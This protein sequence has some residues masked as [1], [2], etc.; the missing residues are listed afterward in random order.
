[1]TV[2][3][4]PL[5]E[6]TFLG[7]GHNTQGVT[8]LLD[9][10]LKAFR[11]IGYHGAT[12]R[13]IAKEVGVTPATVYHHF[14]SKQEI[15]V[16]IMEKA[17]RDNISAV[18]AAYEA[19][20]Q[21]DHLAQLGAMIAAIVDYHAEYPEE[22]FVGNSELRSLEEEGFALIAALRN[23]EEDFFIQLID[24]GVAAG[25]FTTANSKFAAR[26]LISLASSVGNWYRPD[27]PLSID[28]IRNE[29]VEYATNMIR[30]DR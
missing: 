27:G 21:G 22:A 19:A 8:V 10:A 30:A 2:Q 11:K 4:Q 16:R 3:L 28:E 14:E 7:N 1:M 24:S 25:V 18:V 15:L 13:N 20:P 5:P 23:A 26:A 6:K 12:I 9:A 29:Y 17:M